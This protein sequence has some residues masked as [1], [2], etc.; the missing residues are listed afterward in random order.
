MGDFFIGE[1]RAFAANRVPKQWESCDGQLL[2]LNSATRPLFTL[3]GNR[4]GGDGRLNFAVPNLNGRAPMGAGAGEG[5]TAR[6]LATSDGVE[7][8]LL[9]MEHYPPHNHAFCTAGGWADGPTANDSSIAWANVLGQGGKPTPVNVYH[10]AGLD[11]VAL[12]AHSI[13]GY[14]CGEQGP[15]NNMQP[16]LPVLLCMAVQGIY[17][18][19]PD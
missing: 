15:H 12:D 17:P 4:F 18:P 9:G 13:Q 10:I 6:A 3:I 19:R 8:V 2:P 11:L 7:T 16:F 1:V 14:S 5:L